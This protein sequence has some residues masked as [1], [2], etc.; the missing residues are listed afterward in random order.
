MSKPKRIV[1]TG[2]L[3]HIGSRLVR[4]LPVAF[5]GTQII[6]IDNLVTQRYGSL[7]DLPKNGKYKFIG[8]DILDIDLKKF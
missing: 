5:P 3:G 6:M 4:D 2:A 8:A 1:I 7:F